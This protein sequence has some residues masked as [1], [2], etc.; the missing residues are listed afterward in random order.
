MNNLQHL[1]NRVPSIDI[2]RGIVILLMLVDHVR[3]RVFLHQQVADPM[4]I[5]ETSSAL[6]FTR[7]MAHFCAPVFI[8]LTGL[9]AWLYANPI[10]KPQRDVR[11]FLLKRGLFIIFL[12]ITLVNLSWFG[13]YNAL[14]LQ[15]MWAIG[16]CMITL[17]VLTLLSHRVIG[18]LGILIIF[19]HNALDF[20]TFKPDE[21]GYSL[22]T[23]LHD[24]GFLYVGE[25]A[26]D[27]F[28]VK[29]SYPTLPWIGVICLG[30]Y[31]APLFSASVDS[32]KRVQTLF[33]LGAF[34]LV[35]LLAV[36]LLNVYLEPVPWS[37]YDSWLLTVQS[38]VNFTK[39]PPSL[40]FLLFTL[41]TAFIVLALVEKANATKMNFLRH[42]GSAPM[43][44]YL[45]HLY[46]LLALYTVLV[47]IYGT[48]KGVYF[49]VDHVWQVWA[50]S[51]VLSILLYWPTKAFSNFKK[52]T[53]LAWVKYF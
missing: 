26:S 9:S 29:V 53:K 22:W 18:I 43:F 28:K 12:E 10:N 34:S 45:A 13:N 42:Y 15:V 23:I 3:E 37:I 19:G 5:D 21:I 35:S 7:L 41:G 27:A 25:G 51:V 44:F 40:G 52:T 20:I 4:N 6:F 8:F 11:A 36:R 46:V 47:A 16:L 33:K 24:R 2:L 50:I 1:K 32:K 14:Y 38:F 31:V 17:A 48:N 39:Y 30:Y 49:G